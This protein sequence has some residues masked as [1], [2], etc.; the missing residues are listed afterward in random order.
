MLK[1]QYCAARLGP[2]VKLNVSTH[3]RDGIARTTEQDHIAG[4]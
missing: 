4:Q 2:E 1:L 3:G